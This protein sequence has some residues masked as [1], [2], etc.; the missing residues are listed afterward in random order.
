[1]DGISFTLTR[2][3]VLVLALASWD[4]I[5]NI[6]LPYFISGMTDCDLSRLASTTFGKYGKRDDHS[7]SVVK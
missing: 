6:S 7:R 2:L 5:F 4:I 3:S 1:M